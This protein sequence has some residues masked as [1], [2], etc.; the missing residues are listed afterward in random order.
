MLA[1][2]FRKTGAGQPVVVKF[3][4]HRQV[5]QEW[6]NYKDFVQP[7]I[8]GNRSTSVI[9]LRRSLH[10]GGIVYSCSAAPG[11]RLRAQRLLRPRRGGRDQDRVAA[12][13]PGDLQAVVRE[14]AASCSCWT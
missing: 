14:T 7:F 5:D 10:L 4:D 13:L 2:P 3:G 12:P 6:K 11:I 9:E 1:T 8:G